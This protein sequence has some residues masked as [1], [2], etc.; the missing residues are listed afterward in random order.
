MTNQPIL[1]VRA[2]DYGRQP[3]D[4]LCA[5]IAADGWKTI[6]LAFPKAVEGIGS[7]HDVTPPVVEAAAEALARSSL[8][9][10]VLG[11]YVEPSLANEAR[12]LEQVAAFRAGIP[13]AKAL[14]AGCIGTE[15]TNMAHQPGVTRREALAQLK[16]SLAA[17]L[18]L[19][20]ELGV[21]VAVE[22]V[23]YH[24]MAT[25]ELT[26]E[27]LRDMASPR[28]AVIFDPVNLLSSDCLERQEE[29]FDRAFACFGDRIAAVHLKGAYRDG[30]ALRGGPLKGSLLRY[31][32]VIP[33][34][35]GISGPLPILR[36]EAV[37]A[38]AESDR[39]FLQELFA[40]Y[41]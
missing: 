19:A 32:R 5:A 24:A 40:E 4:R 29:L 1:G 11:C 35:K 31:D 18:P 6:Q 10:A 30:D 22:P 28:L 17:L 37:P 16:Q 13:A 2:H 12:R 41:F 33:P 38:E 3:V 21:T 8:S 9:V 25:P 34:L 39:A 14:G 23:S 15:T 36:E 26:R 27:V 7:I 20:E